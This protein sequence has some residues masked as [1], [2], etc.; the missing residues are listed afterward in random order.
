VTR[1][2][3]KDEE[4][5]ER[6]AFAEVIIPDTPNVYGDFHTKQSVKDFAYGFMMAG[7]GIDQEHDNLDVSDRVYVVE[8]FIV[9]PGDPDF[10]EGAWVVAVHVNDDELWQ[11]ILDGDINGFSYEAFVKIIYANMNIPGDITRSGTTE[12][13]IY[14]GH[15]HQFFVMLDAD[16]RPMLGGTSV[17]NGHSHVISQH[18]FTNT[19]FEHSHIYNFVEGKGGR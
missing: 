10:I 14:D 5:F 6:I 19:A 2:I 18:T 15:T 4:G 7:F 8:S 9:R 11:Q 12:P 1:I 17:T 3:R 13:E 16:G